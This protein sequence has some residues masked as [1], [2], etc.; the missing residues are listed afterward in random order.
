LYEYNEEKKKAR[1][2]DPLGTSCCYTMG[3]FSP[4]GT[5][6]LFAYQNVSSGD[7]QTDL[8][9]VSYGSIGSG[10]TYTPLPI[11][12]LFTNPNNHLEAA[13]RPVP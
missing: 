7:T 13:L 2:I 10:A 5:Q 11:T 12:G 3:R 6:L 4:D 8:Y 1:T 9:Y